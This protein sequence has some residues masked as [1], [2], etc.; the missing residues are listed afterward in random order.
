MN[1]ERPV[2]R[3]DLDVFVTDIV[4]YK[5]KAHMVIASSCGFEYFLL[6]L[7]GE[8]AGKISKKYRT[9]SE[10]DSDEQVTE[11]LIHREDVVISKRE[12]VERCPF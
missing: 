8:S 11:L 7:E 6:C 10:I 4:E 1:F 12:G 2:V 5:R 3:H 9:L